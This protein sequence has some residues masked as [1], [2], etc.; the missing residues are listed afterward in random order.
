MS[1]NVGSIDYTVTLDTGKL[2]DGQRKVEKS[3]GSIGDAGDKMK[4]RMTA[5]AAAVSAALSAIAI[6]AFTSKIIAA[7]RQFDVMFASLKTMTGGAD[8][9]SAA[10]AKLVEFA[11]KTP[12]SLEQAVQ[13]FTKLKALGLDPSER[14]MTSFGNTASAMGKDLMQMVEAVA[15]AA[16][17]EFERLKEFGVKAKAQGDNVSLTFQGVTTTIK[18]SA[19]E[20]TEYLTKIGEVQFAGAMSDRMKTLDG[21]ISNLDDSMQAL[22]LSI[23]QSGFG[24]VIASSVRKATEAIQEATTSIKEG[25]LTE[26]FEGLK[27]YIVA[28]EV[29]VIS[30]AGAITGMLVKA[31]AEAAVKAY[32]TAAGVGAATIAARGFTAVLAVM[33]GPIGIAVTALG[34][35]ALNW[36]K[37]SNKAKNAAQISEE[38]A[39]RI[40]KAQGKS[41]KS[42][43]SDLQGQL[44]GAEGGLADTL[45]KLKDKGKE[46]I[47][48]GTILSKRD[49]SELEANKGAYLASIAEIKKAMTAVEVARD[50]GMGPHPAPAAAATGGGSNGGGGKT[51]TAKFDSA[52]YLADL[53][54]NTVDAWDAIGATEQK[55]LLDAKFKL[56]QK[57]LNVAEHE[58]A[59]TLIAQ[60]ATKDRQDLIVKANEDYAAEM[61]RSNQ[62]REAA[63]S[64]RSAGRNTALRTIAAVNPLDALQLEE[65]QRI[66]MF[67]RYR[68]DD[69]GSA[70]IYEDAKTAVHRMASEERA[71]IA[72]DEA[73]KQ[74]SN[75]A[76]SVSMAGDLAGSMYQLMEKTGN[77]KS[78]LGKALFLT[79]K[80]LAVAEIL[81]NTEVAAS[82]AGA[83][84]GIFGIP[85]A[86]MIRATGYASAGMVAGMAIA[87]AR[88]YGGPVSAGSMYRVNETGAPEMFTAN[89]GQQQYMLPSASGKVTAADKVGGGVQVL[90][91]VTNNHPT[92]QVTTQTDDTGRIVRIAVAEVANQISSNSGQVW[93]ALRGSSNVQ[94][95]M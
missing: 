93:S 16:T 79:A 23:S 36:D 8:Q 80:A 3:L 7:Q 40:A 68:Q 94:G 2:I 22:Y 34:L 66:E 83:Q 15:D 4:T 50:G 87:G 56:S 25:G 65:D 75:N 58:K 64:K 13:G 19:S 41:A 63:E 35:L 81:L 30:L 74:A 69:L 38:S 62:E 48:G 26:Y 20:I 44:Q 53:K 89:N 76:A 60:A 77:E 17:G 91:Q 54:K 88:Q 73:S 12:Y 27:P 72:Q 32:A 42:A 67:E 47:F 33:G 92:A 28:A 90:V 43:A 95:R 59:V 14:A 11:A 45:G 86:V 71:R 9:A 46:T 78:A 82:K 51:K 70:Q 5:V 1:E 37:I 24:D 31:M 84:L 21:D 39:E 6:D 57:K 49:V 10:W 18:N 85:M 55:A 61:S 52:S 29:A